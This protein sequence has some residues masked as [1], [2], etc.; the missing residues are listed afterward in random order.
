VSRL[1]RPT[2]RP[3][4]IAHRGASGIVPEQTIEAFDLAVRLGADAIELDIV[5]TRDG[6][7]LARHENELSAT[8]NVANRPELASRRTARTIEGGTV[9]GWFSDDFRADEIARLRARQRFPFRDHAFDDRFPVPTLDDVLR[10]RSSFSL[11]TQIFIEIKHQTYFA[12][13]GL[14][15]PPLLTQALARHGALDRD[16]GIV[17]M[18]FETQVL[19]ELRSTTDLPL[20]QLLDAPDAQPYD[21]TAS[22]DPR[23]Y[24]DLLTVN[25]LTQIAT[26]ADG[27]GPWKRLIVPAIG[28]DGDDG[29]SDIS[30]A[31]PTSLVDDAH[32]AGLFVCA[33]TFRD[34][35]QFLARDYAGDPAREYA[36]FRPLAL[37]AFIA[38]FPAT[39]LAALREE[40]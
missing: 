28:P 23:T 37:D 21:F 35:A 40:T 33:W 8:T 12:S 17:L 30:L 19:K 9:T 24:A 15:I 5:P 7:L 2:T 32:A 13:R 11:N 36:Q 14:A 29:A 31:A 38:D 18:S 34:D 20:I 25:G 16:S 6:V 27:I 4:V 10:W 3:L 39:A 26:Y 22:G 1:A